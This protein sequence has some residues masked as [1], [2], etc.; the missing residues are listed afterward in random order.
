MPSSSLDHVQRFVAAAVVHERHVEP[1][2]CGNQ[3][4]FQYLWTKCVGRD[5][6]DVVAA[7]FLEADHA[8]CRLRRRVYGT[9]HEHA[10]LVVLAEDAFQAAARQKD[11]PGASRPDERSFLAKVGKDAG[12][13]E[14]FRRAAV[15]LRPSSRFTLHARGQ[16]VHE[17]SLALRAAIVASSLPLVT[18]LRYDGSAVINLF[19][20]R[21]W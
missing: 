15:T 12:D 21:E 2:P 17:D 3:D 18:A 20:N 13:H 5:E 16:R 14:V 8:R 4:R 7:P 11:S 6:V 1:H 9:V 19:K 10:D